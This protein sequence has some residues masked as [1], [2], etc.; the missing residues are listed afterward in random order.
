MVHGNRPT[1]WRLEWLQTQISRLPTGS[2]PRTP[3][4]RSG[5]PTPP[6]Y[7]SLADLDH[8]YVHVGSDNHYWFQFQLERLADF[9]VKDQSFQGVIEKLQAAFPADHAKQETLEEIDTH[10]E[11]I[12]PGFRK[13][14]G[15]LAEPTTIP[16]ITP[17]ACQEP[18]K[19]SGSS[20]LVI[21]NDTADPLVVTHPDGRNLTI[22]A[23]QW[24]TYYPIA[25]GASWKLPDGTCLAAHDEPTLAV[26]GKQ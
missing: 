26:I 11:G 6:R 5:R 25:A 13:M 10:L 19:T 24:R 15:S 8:L 12:R 20:S 18:T 17:S 1:N 16:R 23:H 9:L 21:R 14:A 22:P 3:D 2:C 7:T 4:R